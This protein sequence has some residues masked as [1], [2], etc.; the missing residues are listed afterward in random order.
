MF[1]AEAP[2]EADD[3]TGAAFVDPGGVLL[4]RM[5]HAMGLRRADVYTAYVVMCRPSGRGPT[6]D[7]VGTCS[8]WLARQIE[9]VRPD[10][11]VA[12]GSLV[13]RVVTGRNATIS[14]QRGDWGEATL[15]GLGTPVMPTFALE[16]MLQNSKLKAPV[17]ADLRKVMRRLDLPERGRG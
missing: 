3:L 2:A 13:A 17:W 7:E 8:E 10:V 16:A 14:V 11:I 12:L 1:V 5:V 4:S 9:V 15:G 6:D